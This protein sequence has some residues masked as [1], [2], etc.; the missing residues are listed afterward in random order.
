MS[1]AYGAEKTSSLGTEAETEAVGPALPMP[2]FVLFTSMTPTLKA[3]EKASQLATPLRAG[4]QIL[5]MQTVPYLLPLTEPPVRSEFI[6]GRFKEMAGHFPEK[7]TF[8]T[9]LCRDSTQALAQVLPHDSRVVMGIRKRWWPTR[10]GRLA[11]RLVHDG[12]NVILVETE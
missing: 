10:D 7:T 6:A 3:L 8:S 9:Y 1:T 4:I 5:A 2:V 11:R 12:Y